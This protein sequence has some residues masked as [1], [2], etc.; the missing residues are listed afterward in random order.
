MTARFTVSGVLLAALLVLLS[1][2]AFADPVTAG[3]PLV[4]GGYVQARLVGGEDMATSIQSKRLYIR[5]FS[6][7]SDKTAVC[8]LLTG[9]PSFGTLE[10]FGQYNDKAD[11]YRMGLYHTPFGYEAGASSAALVTTERSFVI[12]NMIYLPWTFDRGFYWDHAMKSGVNL[13]VALTEGAPMMGGLPGARQYSSSDD[14]RFNVTARLG[15]KDAKSD[16]GVSIMLIPGTSTGYAAKSLTG[17]DSQYVG[18]DFQAKQKTLAII[19]EALV[20]KQACGCDVNG[21]YVTVSQA[22]K[23]KGTTPY[24]RFDMIDDEDEDGVTSRV[25]VGASRMLNPLT[26]VSVEGELID[27]DGSSQAKGTVQ[28]Q[29]AL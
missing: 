26:K 25:T 24:V 17:D 19:A 22:L 3:S 5:G 20:G 29:T 1:M 12:Q 6:Q 21:F 11:T 9:F 14:S 23:G 16:M 13:K 7:T 27:C 10:A 28:Y 18:V 2:P 4:I 15:K 8:F